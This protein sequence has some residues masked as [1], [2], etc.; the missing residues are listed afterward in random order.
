MREWHLAEGMTIED[1]EAARAEFLRWL[2]NAERKLGI[3]REPARQQDRLHWIA[4]QA[5]KAGYGAMWRQ[6]EPAEQPPTSTET[7]H[8]LP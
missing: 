7:H 5:F 6:T 4:K 2:R 3:R 8:V 1:E